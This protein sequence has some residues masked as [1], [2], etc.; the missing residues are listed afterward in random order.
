M[1]FSFFILISCLSPL[2]LIILLNLF[3]ISFIFFSEG[4]LPSPKARKPQG[5]HN[6]ELPHLLKAQQ[7]T[8]TDK[9][10]YLSFGALAWRFNCIKSRPRMEEGLCSKCN[11]DKFEEI[12]SR[13]TESHK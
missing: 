13:V 11:I 10:A 3:V 12:L 9:L 1:N 7:A 4:Y 8:S 2:S 6:L 5:Q